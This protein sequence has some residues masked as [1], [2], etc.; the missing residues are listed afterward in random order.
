M[1]KTT[2]GIILYEEITAKYLPFFLES[3]KAQTENNFSLLVYDNSEIDLLIN[4]KYLDEEKL[5]YAYFGTGKNI[6]FG[7]AYNVLI[8]EAKKNNSDYFLIINPDIIF[9]PNFLQLLISSL[10]EN[11][12][13]SSVAPKL[14]QWQFDNNCKTN[15]IDSCGIIIKPALQFFDLGQGELD[16][17]Q[18][19]TSEIL[20]PSGAASLFKISAL[21]EIREGDNYFDE[22]FFMYKEDCDLVMRMTLKNQ[23]SKL[24]PEAI[25]YHDRTAFAKGSSLRS[26][27]K[28]RRLRSRKVSEWSFINQQLLYAKYWSTLNFKNKFNLIKQQISLLIYISLFEEYL[29]FSLIKLAK[30]R[31]KVKYYG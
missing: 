4:K 26:R 7:A 5:T 2:I 16:N 13:L 28:A 18:F 23:K 21:D 29:F 27:I 25:G 6:G 15:T 24:I 30:L 19:N 8:K 1:S 31:C 14:L 3:L 10:E 20:G 17:G 9:E 22:H 11:N 12:D